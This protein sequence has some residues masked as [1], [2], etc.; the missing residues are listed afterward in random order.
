MWEV[1]LVMKF[2][3]DCVKPEHS[4]LDPA[5][6]NQGLRCQIVMCKQKREQSMAEGNWHNLVLRLFSLLNF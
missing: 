4:E 6:S 5:E 1:I 2:E 3:L